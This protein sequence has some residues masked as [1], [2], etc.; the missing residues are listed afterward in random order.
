METL[1]QVLTLEEACDLLNYK[2]SY[3][4]KLTSSS[5]IPYSKPNGKKLFFDREKLLT[6][7]LSNPKKSR[8][9]REKDAATYLG[10]LDK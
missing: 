9:E 6:W 4:Y 10:K 7:M 5:I 1:K 2:K 8:N 3:V